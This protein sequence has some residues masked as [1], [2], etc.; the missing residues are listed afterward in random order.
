M[1]FTSASAATAM[2]NVASHARGDSHARGSGDVSRSYHHPERS[3]TAPQLPTL[4]ST[5]VGSTYGPGSEYRGGGEAGMGMDRRR[6]VP[7]AS[8]YM[9]PLPPRVNPGGVAGH[10]G[11]G[12]DLVTPYG[13][14]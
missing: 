3:Y 4:G 10:R 14:I 1:A 7:P 2:K 8:T 6:I 13:G 11:G 12:V 5:Y 9:V